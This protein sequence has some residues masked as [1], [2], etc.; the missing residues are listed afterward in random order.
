MNYIIQLDK[1]K[2]D[3]AK[4]YFGCAFS[5]SIFTFQTSIN[6]GNFIIWPGIESLNF[7]K[8]L[9]TTMASELGHLDQERSNLQSTSASNSTD[10]TTTNTEDFFHKP[11]KETKQEYFIN[12]LQFDQKEKTFVDLTGRFPHQSSRG[13]NYIMVLYDYDGNAILAQ[14]LKNRESQSIIEAWKTLYNRLY[15]FGHTTRT[16]IMDNEASSEF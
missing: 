2:T 13:N 7:K 3:L 14:A 5:P 15:K 11:I 1:S 10:S 4:Y 12:L 16:Y 8:L 6:K 9:G